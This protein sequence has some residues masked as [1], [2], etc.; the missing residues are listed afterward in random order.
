[1]ARSKKGTFKVRTTYIHGTDVTLCDTFAEAEAF[2][3]DRM[4]AIRQQQL[5]GLDRTVVKVEMLMP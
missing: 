2:F 3:A 5:D 1:M 4:A